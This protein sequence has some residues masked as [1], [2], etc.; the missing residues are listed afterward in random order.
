[1]EP[2]GNPAPVFWAP[3]GGFLRPVAQRALPPEMVLT[4]AA[5]AAKPWWHLLLSTWIGGAS[6]FLKVYVVLLTLRIYVTWF[7]N[8]NTYRQPFATLARM[9]DPYMRVFRG[10][11]PALFGLDLSPILGFFLINAAQDYLQ[12]LALMYV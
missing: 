7:V 11:L 3:Q 9:T 4:R 10:I 12:K 2:S 6:N 1:V 8:I 5:V